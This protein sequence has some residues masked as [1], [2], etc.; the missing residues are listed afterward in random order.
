MTPLR[1]LGRGEMEMMGLRE[2]KGEVR[3]V[4]EESLSG[5]LL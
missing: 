1:P 3:E 5:M 4:R 2:V